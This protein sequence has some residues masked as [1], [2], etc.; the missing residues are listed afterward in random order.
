[1]RSGKPERP[2]SVREG[3][4]LAAA[5]A[6]FEA[7]TTTRMWTPARG[8]ILASLILIS[9]TGCSVLEGE[10][11]EVS[12][13]REFEILGRAPTLELTVS[14]TGSG[15]ARI[16][17]LLTQ[18]GEEAV[19]VDETFEEPS[20]A[21]VSYDIG[22]MM[23]DD[24]MPQEGA[25][26]LTVMTSDGS[27]RGNESETTRAFQFD[28]YPPQLQVLSPLLYINQGGS[29]N[30]IYR[31]SDDAVS[32]GVQVG[33]HFFPG[34][35]ANIPD[36]PDARFALFAFAYNLPADTPVTVVARDAAGNEAVAGVSNQVSSGAFRNRE[37]QV[38]DGFLQKVVPEIMSRTT[39]IRDQ[40]SLI[41][42]YVEINS[43]LR[44]LNHARVTEMS[45]ASEGE[46]LWD[47]GFLQLSNSQVESLF[48]DHRTYFYEG[49]EVDQQDH[50]GFDLSVVARYPIEATNAGRVIL[51][52]Y[53]GIYGNTV[54]IDHGVGLI[55][56]YGHMS[57][58]DVEAG[59][60]VAKAEIL[61]R[62]GETGLAG[63]DHLHF[64]LFLHG[65]P[66]NPIEWWDAMWVQDHILDRLNVEN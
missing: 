33:P 31:V 5:E 11:P 66:V 47:G 34:F 61:G 52:E 53:F 39:E 56:L 59:Q 22:R 50:V 3:P 30:L 26:I 60:S 27:L 12:F 54:L 46:F 13:D 19:L 28:L 37:I 45:A 17:V 62:S 6:T 29:E 57:S 10:P 64:G 14:D 63:G 49:E 9:A 40:G 21:P 36:D 32:S 20:E 18:D 23:A 2:L 58:I 42:T 38:D 15:V 51:A 65:V 55:S 16:R 25:A 7:M 48:A 35:P 8:V 41:D 43:R 44:E 4:N 1:V 24:F